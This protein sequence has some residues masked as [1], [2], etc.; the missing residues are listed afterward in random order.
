MNLRILAD[1]NMPGLERFARHGH[2]ERMPGRQ[3]TAAR[4]RHTDVLLARSVTRLDADLLAGTP[5]R[6]AG[7][8]TIGTDHVDQAWLA[9]QGI[10]FAHAPGCNA[11]A[12][13]EYALQAVLDWLVEQGGEPGALRVA[14]VGCGRVG[15][16]AA[17]LFRAAGFE[18]LVCDPPRQSAGERLPGTPVALD[19]ALEADIVSLHVPLT[20]EGE[21][22]SFHML[23]EPRLWRLSPAQLLI[24]TGRGAVIDNGALTRRLQAGGPATVL[25]VWEHEPGIDPALFRLCRQGTPHVA[26]YSREGK[27]RGTAMLYQAFRH[28]LGA[29]G[30]AETVM[31][32][33][34]E[35][36]QPVETLADVLALLRARYDLRRDHGA[37]AAS[38]DE[39]DPG[40]AFDALRRNYPVRH[41]CAGL[42]VSGLVAP[43]W[44]PLLRALGVTQ[45]S[46]RS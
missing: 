40:A 34:A 13:A 32:P 26:G 18:V 12:V 15:T 37:L 41:E 46:P 10:A 1:E 14:V 5:V 28:W 30:D 36:R 23:D 7:S 2:L 25:D 35:L 9:E 24:N 39:P 29:P 27:E 22:A 17:G 8:A 20:R 4:L 19:T 33:A 16:R 3:I 43:E 45:A 38:L 42:R 31:P 6:F 44:T 21:H 11:M